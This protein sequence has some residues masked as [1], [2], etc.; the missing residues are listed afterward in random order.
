[1]DWR[2]SGLV[3]TVRGPIGFV[4]RHLTTEHTSIDIDIR[5]FPSNSSSDFGFSFV[6]QG[7]MHLWFSC[8]V[9]GFG[10]LHEGLVLGRRHALTV[11]SRLNTGVPSSYKI[12][13]NYFL[14]ILQPSFVTIYIVLIL[15]SI[16]HELRDTQVK[17]VF[18]AEPLYITIYSSG[19]VIFLIGLVSSA[20]DAREIELVAEGVL[21][22][23][24]CAGH[25]GEDLTV[26]VT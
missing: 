8:E 15:P 17:V 11:N 4:I 20:L 16:I 14:L 21:V 23:I 24:I 26:S 5:H 12:L 7:F 9:S 6:E 19:S 3:E 18:Q 10:S 2:L 1:M 13:F 22:A 25:L